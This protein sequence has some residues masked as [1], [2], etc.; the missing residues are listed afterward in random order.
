MSN[1]VKDQVSILV[2]LLVVLVIPRVHAGEVST[3]ASAEHGAGLF[4]YRCALCHGSQGYG[5]GL[6]TLAIKDYPHANLHVNKYGPSANTLRRSISEGGSDDQ[7]S[8]AM[9]PWKSEL[10]GVE[11]DSLVMFVQKLLHSPGDISR[12]IEKA[13]TSLPTADTGRKLYQSF[14]VLCHGKTGEG[15]G[16][17]SKII[18]NPPP[19]NL[20]KSVAPR[21][22][23]DSIIRLGGA[24]MGRSERMPP[25]SDQLTQ[26]EVDSIIRYLLTIRTD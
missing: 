9:P 24:K 6:L 5:D 10:S 26:N 4:I 8:D 23:L 2:F 22:Y 1:G 13:S 12:M 20:T 11:I 15:D 3:E 14:C 7:M 21:E 17:L 18:K 25:W 19:F 16:K